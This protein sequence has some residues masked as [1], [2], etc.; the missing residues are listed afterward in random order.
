[1]TEQAQEQRLDNLRKDIDITE[2]L[3][4]NPDNSQHRSAATFTIT[5]KSVSRPQSLQV[6]SRLLKDFVQNSLGGKQ[7]GSEQAEQFLSAQIYDYGRRLSEAEQHIADFK[8]QN[9][10][11]LPGQ[12]GDYFTRLQ[13]QTEALTQAKEKLALALRKQEAL[14]HELQGGQPFVAGP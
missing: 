5:Y 3:P 14:Q 12:Q 2:E 11:L 1:P 6:V 8:R 13:T 7:E 10:G 9:V 4:T